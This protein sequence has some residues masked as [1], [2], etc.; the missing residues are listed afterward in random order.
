MRTCHRVVTRASLTLLYSYVMA[1][2]MQISL[3]AQQYETLNAEA[4]R[5]GLS[6]AELVRRAV[7]GVY[8]PQLR[9]S[10]SRLEL[11]VGV[12]RKPDA[13]TTGRRPGIRLRD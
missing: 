12:W 7:D 4:W 10:A 3:T 9:P 2:R 6:I 5:T 13:A 11:S 8:R 1:H